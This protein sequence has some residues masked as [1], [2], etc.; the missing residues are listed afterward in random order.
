MCSVALSPLQEMTIVSELP[1]PCHPVPL[2]WQRTGCC[3][4]GCCIRRRCS[5]LLR[6]STYYDHLAPLMCQTLL[7]L[8]RTATAQPQS[9]SAV[10]DSSS[11]LS[12]LRKTLLSLWLSSTLLSLMDA[13]PSLTR[14]RLVP[15]H[16]MQSLLCW[17]TTGTVFSTVMDTQMHGQPKQLSVVCL[18]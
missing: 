11:A 1:P 13:L 3:H 9:H 6:R 10:T 14:S 15:H 18:T 7:V 4:E 16:V 2:H 8:Q 12:V 5:R 17:L